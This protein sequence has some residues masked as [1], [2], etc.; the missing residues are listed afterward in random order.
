MGQTETGKRTMQ[1]LSD[2]NTLPETRQKTRNNRGGVF[3]TPPLFENASVHLSPEAHH[4]AKVPPKP[5]MKIPPNPQIKVVFLRTPP[6]ALGRRGVG[7]SSNHSMIKNVSVL[8]RA[9][10]QSPEGLN[11]GCGP[12]TRDQ[13]RTSLHR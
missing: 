2:K 13:H 9:E 5:Q 12:L 11:P 4:E 3:R 7:S 10:H 8:G 6:F 1:T